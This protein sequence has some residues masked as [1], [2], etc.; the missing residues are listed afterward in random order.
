VLWAAAVARTGGRLPP[1]RGA[2]VPWWTSAS[3]RISSRPKTLRHRLSSG[4]TLWRPRP[5]RHLLHRVQPSIVPRPALLLPLTLRRGDRVP[6]LQTERN[7]GV[8][9]RPD[10]CRQEVGGSRW[11]GT[12]TR[13]RSAERRATAAVGFHRAAITR[14]GSFI[15]FLADPRRIGFRGVGF[16]LSVDLELPPARH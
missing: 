9:V 4:R 2:Y 8:V 6:V 16:G 3:P 1:W 10:G 12:P 13:H 15:V 5:P 14:K 7:L 11:Q